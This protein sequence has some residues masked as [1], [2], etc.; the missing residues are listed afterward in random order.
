MNI[1][2][3]LTHGFGGTKEP[4]RLEG[5]SGTAEVGTRASMGALV[6]QGDEN[7]S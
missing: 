5:S 3:C 2:A 1:N 7:E 4:L 6:R